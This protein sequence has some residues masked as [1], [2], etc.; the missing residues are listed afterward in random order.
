MDLSEEP[1][2]A[3]P[4]KVR[5]KVRCMCFYLSYVRQK[6]TYGLLLVS[7]TPSVQSIDGSS[8]DGASTSPPASLRA[9]PSNARRGSAEAPDPIL[10]FIRPLSLGKKHADALRA[11]GIHT[12]E[13]LDDLREL[14][15]GTLQDVLGKVLVDSRQFSL[16]E[17]MKL[18]SAI[19]KR[20]D[21]D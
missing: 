20:N 21:E 11:H 6:I 9:G 19:L 2:P 1:E 17:W 7:P 3:P 18:R 15:L 4:R 13:H 16:L 14:D 8:D 5:R 10:V 12:K